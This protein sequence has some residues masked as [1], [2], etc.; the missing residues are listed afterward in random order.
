LQLKRADDDQPFRNGKASEL[1]LSGYK[2]NEE[3]FTDR[4]LRGANLRNSTFNKSNFL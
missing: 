2:W 3:D 4:D 1:N